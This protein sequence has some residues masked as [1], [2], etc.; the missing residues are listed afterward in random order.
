MGEA[1]RRE[2]PRIPESKSYHHRTTLENL[3]W[4]DEWLIG[5]VW[6]S[7]HLEKL[8]AEAEDRITEHWPVIP[9]KGGI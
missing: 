3:R 4:G 7:E 2:P 8:E 9:K 1:P 6:A 5:Q